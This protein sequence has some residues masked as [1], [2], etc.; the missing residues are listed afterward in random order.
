MQWRM[1]TQQWKFI[2]GYYSDPDE[3][4]L[5]FKTVNL[6]P[7]NDDHMNEAFVMLLYY[8]YLGNLK[9]YMKKVKPVQWNRLKSESDN[10]KAQEILS[11]YE[12][13]Y[14]LYIANVTRK[15]QQLR[16]IK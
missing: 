13:A 3:P 7:C 16:A 9:R 2:S 1:L 12:L 11:M 6:D 5:R 15:R 4:V 8:P 14:T 10:D